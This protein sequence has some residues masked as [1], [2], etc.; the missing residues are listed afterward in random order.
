[1]NVKVL[2]TCRDPRLAEM[3]TLVFDSLRVG[4]PTANVTVFLNGD[5]CE[6]HCPDIRDAAILNGCE[7]V[8]HPGTIHHLWIEELV[9][10]ETDPFYLLDT[11]VVFY[12]SMERFTFQ[13]P[14]AGWRIPEWKDEFTNA[15]TRARLHTSVLYIDPVKVREAIAKYEI[16]FPVTPFNP[17]INLFHPVCLPF[18]EQGYFYDTCSLLYHAIGGESFTPEQL[19]SYMHFHFGTIPDVVLPRLAN[20]EA[21]AAARRDLMDN[22]QRGRGIWKLQMEHYAQ[23]PPQIAREALV[24]PG[25]SEEDGRLALKW[26]RELCRDDAEAMGFC[27][28][29]YHYVHSIDDLLDTAEDGRPRMNSEQILEVFIDAAL[30]YNHSF[31]R[32]HRELLFPVVLMVTNMFA[33]SVAWE[34]SPIKQRRTIANVLSTCGDEMY[35]L[36]AMI[37][38]GWKHARD[39]GPRIRERDF[40]TQHDA[41]CERR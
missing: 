24:I 2:A 4:F 7:V 13:G 35:V 12:E 21:M 5:A 28:L 19:D 39:I 1:M 26:N 3:T 18:K 41:N 25:I 16:Q 6:K 10:K 33:D 11:D 32:K 15:I 22:P 38:G 20:G 30:L 36:V 17:L 8:A 9:A 27:D 29:W 37:C 31:F 34:Q 23:R 14:L 40:T